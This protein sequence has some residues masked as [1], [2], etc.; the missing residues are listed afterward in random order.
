MVSIFCR[1][2]LKPSK[3]AHCITSA[4][5]SRGRR[6]ALA[7]EAGVKFILRL[8]GGALGTVTIYLLAL[9]G[10]AQAGS[11]AEDLLSEKPSSGS[12]FGGVPASEIIVEVRWSGSWGHSEQA[13]ISAEG[14]IEYNFTNKGKTTKR[15]GSIEPALAR[16]FI[17]QLIQM[18]F[19]EL[20]P[21]YKSGGEILYELRDGTLGVYNYG[22]A[23]AGATV[24]RLTF[25]DRDHSVRMPN[26]PNYVPSQLVNW[27]SEVKWV[28]KEAVSSRN[29]WN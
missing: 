25:G 14:A 5:S 9:L 13:R 28:V 20:P 24:V 6:R 21:Q 18:G 15:E 3:G 11:P 8:N 10:S 23:D 12:D 1:E 16:H 29:R 22:T 17:G 2:S 19:F 27:C 4:C 26:P 7:G